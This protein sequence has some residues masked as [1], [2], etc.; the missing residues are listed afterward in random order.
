MHGLIAFSLTLGKQETIPAVDHYGESLEDNFG[1]KKGYLGESR[2]S[3][4]CW[5]LEGLWLRGHRQEEHEVL[6]MNMRLP[7]NITQ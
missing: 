1:Y 3:T 6:L 5:P 7:N 4:L 2:C